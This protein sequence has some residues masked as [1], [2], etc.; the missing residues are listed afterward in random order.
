KKL[1]TDRTKFQDPTMVTAIGVAAAHTALNLNCRAIVAATESGH[2]AQMISKYRPHADI[3]AVTPHE[4]VA[5]QLQLVWGVHPIVKPG[6][7]NTDEVLNTSVQA[8]LEEGFVTEGDLIII[9]AGVPTGQAGTTNL[10]KLHVV[11]DTLINAQGIGKLSGFGE[12][13]IIESLEDLKEKDTKGKILVLNSVDGMMTPHLVDAAG[14]V[15]VEG[16]LTSPGAIIGLNLEIPTIVGATDAFKVLRN[17]MQ[18][19]INSEQNVV[20]SGH[21]NVL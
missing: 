11:G 19:T 12:V 20:Y 14:L 9:T 17:G 8:V 4:H 1:L 10:M 16:G 15:T 6:D 5:R 7:K 21:A 2:T 3:V 18:V 13:L